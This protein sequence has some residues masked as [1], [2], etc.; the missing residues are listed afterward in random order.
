MPLPHQFAAATSATGAQLDDDFQAAALLAAIPCV[1]SGTNALTLTPETTPATPSVSAYQNYMLFSGVAAN[2]NTGAVTAAAA[3]LATLSVYK[4]SA[5]GPVALT[6]AEIQ[7]GNLIILAYDSALNAGAGGFHLLNAP[8][9]GAPTGAAGGD[10][11]GTY[12]NPNVAKINNVTLGVV[13]AAAGSL[14]VGQGANI[15]TKAVSGDASL[16]AT[17]AL[18]VSATGGVA[19]T[20]GATMPF[21]AATSWTPTDGSGAGLSF[22][23]VHANYVRMG[24]IV[25]AYFSV[26]YPA[27]ADG[28]A[29]IISGLPV[30]VPNQAYAQGPAPMWVS[31]GSIAVI[32]APVQATLTAAFINHATAAAVTNANLSGLTVR[33]MLIYPV[34]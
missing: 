1:V 26:T 9:G 24:N 22:S 34:A 31:G 27:T 4:D 21:V 23:G 10:L 3:S 30:A 25:F 11:S 18:T 15:A 5:S 12:P 8:I 19:L 13:T 29:A 32:L 20:G 16:A 17:G 28:S 2:D 33:G 14:L 7:A 6:G